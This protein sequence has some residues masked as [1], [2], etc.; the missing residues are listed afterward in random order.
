VGSA[1]GPAMRERLEGRLARAL[2]AL[3]PR[4]QIRLSGRPPVI[5]DGDQLAPEL[6]LLLAVLERR[7][8]PRP[9]TMAPVELRA[10]R[11][12]QAA[13]YGS[14]RTA[15]GAV[16]DL[17]IDAGVALRARHYA[18]AEPGGPHPLLVYFHGGGFVIGDLETHDSVCRLLCR[19]AGT[20]VLAVDYRLAPEHPFPAAL[21]DARGALRW[22]SANARAIE[23]DPDRIGVGGD[24]AGGNLAAGVSLLAARDGGP[25]PVLQLLIYPVTDFSGRLRSRELFGEGF[26]LTNAEMDWFESNYLG[27]VGGECARDPRVSPLLAEDLGG[28]APAIVATA[29]FDPLRDEGEEYAAALRR[30]GTPT[31]LRRFPGLIHAFV[32]LTEVSRT[33]RD[34]LIEIAG[35]TRALFAA[36]GHGADAPLGRRIA[37]PGAES[38]ADRGEQPLAPA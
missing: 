17:V 37:A 15:V 24:S 28:L 18:P 8:L 12:R 22:A 19:H 13:V 4:L 6:Q 11:R 31:I 3:P 29:A 34:G 25:S 1:N 32:S 9:E 7:G 27:S 5:I 14:R 20:H 23:A 33:S 36:S 26:F 30:A 35:L 21:D 16:E 10:L 38:A 2:A